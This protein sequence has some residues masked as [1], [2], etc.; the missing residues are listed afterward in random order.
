MDEIQ[1]FIRKHPNDAQAMAATW[2]GFIHSLDVNNIHHPEFFSS[3][4]WFAW[5]KEQ[6]FPVD[7]SLWIAHEINARIPKNKQWVDER[8]L[9]QSQQPLQ[10]PSEYKI[11]E[12][13]LSIGVLTM[14]T[15][16]REEIVEYDQ[17]YR[18][19]KDT[20]VEQ[21]KKNNP[22]KTTDS[23]EFLDYKYGSLVADDPTSQLDKEAKEKFNSEEK[24]EKRRKYYEKKKEKTYKY[25]SI[26][27]AVQL[28]HRRIEYEAHERFVLQKKT[29]PN[30]SYDD[31]KKAVAEKNWRAFAITDRTKAEAYAEKHEGIKTGLE[32]VKSI[33]AKREELK[34]AVPEELAQ[35]TPGLHDE[36]IY[37]PPISKEEEKEGV[38]APA[39][40]YTDKGTFRP[41]DVRAEEKKKNDDNSGNRPNPEQVRRA[42]RAIEQPRARIS[43]RPGP[44][45]RSIDRWNGLTDRFPRRFPS[46]PR[47][48][49]PSVPRVPSVP[50]IPSLPGGATQA[51]SLARSAVFLLN[52]YVLAGIIAVIILLVII[53]VIS[54]GP[55]NDT[56]NPPVSTM[57]GTFQPGDLASCQFTRGSENPPAASYKSPLLLSYFQEASK[58]SGVPA[59]LLAG[60][61]RVESP[62]IVNYTDETLSSFPCAE[63]PTGALGLMQI[64]PQGELG[65]DAGAVT[66]GAKYLGI[67]Y[68]ALTKDDYCDV[69][70]SIFMGAGFINQKRIYATGSEWDPKGINDRSYID[71]VAR[72]YYGCL[73][74]PSC[75]VG[76][77]SYGGDLWTSVQSCQASQASQPNGE[78]NVS[79]SIFDSLVQTA[80]DIVTKLVKQGRYFSLKS[81]EPSVYYWCTYLIIDAYNKVG[82]TGLTRSSHAAVLNMKAY[83]KDSNANGGK[84]QLLSPQTDVTKLKIGDTIF[85][86]GSGADSQ[87]VSLIKSISLDEHGNGVIHTD[88]SNNVV[89]EDVVFV[90]NN[91]ALNAQTTPN[92]KITGFGEMTGL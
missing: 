78:T 36:P 33:E 53:L 19:T 83:F 39:G 29:D 73:L 10:H 72:T 20:L 16:R 24:F 63:S 43:P 88:D 57:P 6:D 81:D 56:E 65:H 66:R 69:R 90:R 59:S 30:A 42:A 58:A 49:L 4:Q 70:K 79:S 31:I 26:D 35:T 76:P 8:Q 61:A 64:E 15:L 71:S 17:D 11:G 41:V 80:D 23:K 68:S 47:P 34:R 1:A 91:Q 38:H 54:G 2:E 14:A 18:K 40:V 46:P 60:F 13:L 21:W 12:S 3:N 55:S 67:E 51:A 45:T 7:S 84:L 74:Y 28:M 92:Y 75:L 85:F 82:I 32:Q 5:A 52:P 48:R 44:L 86:E 89:T 77:Y 50:R 62:G 87:H 27:P 9:Q 25:A 37:S 22:E